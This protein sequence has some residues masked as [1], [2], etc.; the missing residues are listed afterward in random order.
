MTAVAAQ[1][2][3]EA[4]FYW[5]ASN[6]NSREKARDHLAWIFARLNRLYASSPTSTAQL[7]D[8]ITARCINLSSNRIK[9]YLNL[10]LQ[11]IRK[12]KHTITELLKYKGTYRKC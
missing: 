6:S 11:A 1:Q 2:M 12:G 10:L 9:T 3:N 7:E 4:P 5:V 8:K